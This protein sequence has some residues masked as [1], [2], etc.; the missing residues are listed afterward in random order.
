MG[1]LPFDVSQKLD[2]SCNEQN[3]EDYNSPMG[4]QEK[5]RERSGRPSNQAPDVAHLLDI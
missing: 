5:E 4:A 3:P 1:L 2:F